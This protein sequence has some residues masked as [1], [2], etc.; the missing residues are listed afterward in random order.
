MW[1]NPMLKFNHL[2]SYL[3][4]L[5]AVAAAFAMNPG[6]ALAQDSKS[7]EEVVVQAPIEVTEVDRSMTSRTELIE[8]KRRVNIADL[9]LTQQQDVLE[10]ENRIANISAEACDTLA[11]MYPLDNSFRETKKCVNDAIQSAEEQKLRA[12][13][14]AN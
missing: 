6:P 2:S 14:M 1:A 5:A 12:I 8:L 9:D 13:A 3:T 7:L 11:K 4:P 10:L